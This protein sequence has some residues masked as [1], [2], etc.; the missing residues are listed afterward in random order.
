MGDPRGQLSRTV[1]E[2][3]AL[4]FSEAQVYAWVILPLLIFMARIADVTLGTVRL[5]FVS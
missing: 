5:V 4:F 1:I 3:L 2:M